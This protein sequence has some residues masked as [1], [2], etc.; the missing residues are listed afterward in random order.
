MRI[1]GLS[2]TLLLLFGITFVAFA[3][4]GALLVGAVLGWVFSISLGDDKD[5]H[6]PPVATFLF[7]YL[8]VVV[9]ARLQVELLLTGVA[10]GFI[11]GNILGGPILLKRALLGMGPPSAL[12]EQSPVAAV[13]S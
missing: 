12:P 7:A 13:A 10:A 9:A 2:L 6:R 8:V 1:I 5:R 3:A 4:T 11:I